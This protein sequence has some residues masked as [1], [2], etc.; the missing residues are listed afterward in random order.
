MVKHIDL[1]SGIGGFALAVDRVWPGAEH[2]FCD[3]DKFCQAIINK[4]WPDAKI[5]DDIRTLTNTDIVRP[6][7]SRSELQTGRSGQNNKDD[8]TFILTGG[9]PCQPFSQAGQRK[10]TED[11]RYLWPEMLRVIREFQPVW[12]IA[13]NV[14]GLVTWND[15]M[16]LEQVCADLEAEGYDVQPIIIPAVAVNAPHRRDRIWFIAHRN[17]DCHGCT[18]RNQK[19]NSTKTGKSTLNDTEGR[20][21]ESGTDTESE[22]GKCRECRECREYTQLQEKVSGRSNSRGIITD[23]NSDGNRSDKRTTGKKNSIQEIDRKTICTGMSRRT[24]NASSNTNNTRSR[25]LKPETFKDRSENCEERKHSQCRTHGQDCHAE[26]TGSERS[27]GRSKNGRQILDCESAEIKNTRPDS[28]DW[29][30]E[31]REVAFATCNAGVDDGLPI[32]LGGLKLSG[33]GNRNAQ[34]KAYGNAIVPQVAEQ[35]MR[36]IKET[37][38]TP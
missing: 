37:Y 26:N 25:T 13:E 1:F 14:R 8:G 17:T 11:D 12:V 29:N 10:G 4:H 21:D 2:L 32:A 15:G 27:G 9:F 33:A 36:A 6:Q 7:E 22:R 38:D 35:I 30:R 20:C 19:I 3:N 31:W 16:V 34:I 18:G 28:P 23:T 24:D 5:Y